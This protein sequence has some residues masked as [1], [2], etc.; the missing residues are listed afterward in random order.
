MERLHHKGTTVIKSIF[1]ISSALI[2]ALTATALKILIDFL[3]AK[4]SHEGCL[5]TRGK[6]GQ[7]KHLPLQ[8]EKKTI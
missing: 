4:S 6:L 1:S 5:C 2:L 3:K 8:R 7:T